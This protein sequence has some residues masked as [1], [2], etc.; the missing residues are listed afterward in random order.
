MHA[1]FLCL[2]LPLIPLAASPPEEVHYLGPG[3]EGELKLLWYNVENLFHP[4]LDTGRGRDLL[5]ADLEFS[6]QGIRSWTYERYRRKL[7]RVA[8]VIVAAG[9]WEAPALVALCEVENARVLEDLI[10]HP[11]LAPLEY[12]Y[13]HKEGPDH[14]GMDLAL[15]F[16]DEGFSLA[17][18][19]WH[20]PPAHPDLDRTRLILHL[21]GSWGRKAQQLDLL[22][23][24]LVSRYSGSARTAA[25]RR[26]QASRIHRLADSLTGPS[27]KDL[28]L[29]VGD[30]NDEAL[31]WSMMPLLAPLSSGKG[32]VH[33]ALSV[34]AGQE[35]LICAY[36]YRGSWSAID[37]FLLGGALESNA[38]RA[39]VLALPG[40]LE[41][42]ALYGGKKPYRTYVGYRYHGGYSDHLPILLEVSRVKGLVSPFR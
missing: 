34:H 10:A 4:G 30:F 14:R 12:S 32:L 17:H 40:L 11:I 1:L 29:V 3:E 41:E 21:S 2:I 23:C 15:L 38:F 33:P 6:P 13:L 39:S 25:Y 26:E 9:R 31:A 37:R 7:T 27:E 8:Q 22:C 28:L 35:N 36:K 5:E 18:W 20:A 24:H 42:D 19:Q 16:R